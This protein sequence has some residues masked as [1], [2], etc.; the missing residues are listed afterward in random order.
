MSLV[1]R[2][3]L[4]YAGYPAGRGRPRVLDG[5]NDAAVYAAGA[6]AAVL[7][8]AMIALAGPLLTP[9]FMIMVALLG[10]MM[11]RPA[12]AAYLLIGITPLV[13][14]IDRGTVMPALRPNEA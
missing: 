7:L 11:L 2:N 8:A 5:S 9:L 14:G 12:V 6:V 1:N 4:S 13:A 3:E 10:V